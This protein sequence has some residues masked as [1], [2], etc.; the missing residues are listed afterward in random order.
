MLK[1]RNYMMPR[2][3]VMGRV[4]ALTSLEDESEDQLRRPEHG[5]SVAQVGG[6]FGRGVRV[7]VDDFLARSKTPRDA[8]IWWTFRGRAGW[9][10]Y[11][12]GRG[13]AQPFFGR[14]FSP[15]P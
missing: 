14:T 3:E 1:K 4:Q 7:E 5:R 10:L 6:I 8:R 11:L 12:A 15:W 2:C 13:L 9:L